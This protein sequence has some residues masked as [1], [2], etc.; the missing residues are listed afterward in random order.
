MR[1]S[2]SCGHQVELHDNHRKAI[3]SC[4][5]SNTVFWGS[6]I[7]ISLVLIGCIAERKSTPLNTQANPS[8]TCITEGMSLE[9]ALVILKSHH[10]KE[11][12]IQVVSS[13]PND[14]LRFFDLPNGRTLEI[15][16]AADSDSRQT[17]KGMF[18]STYQPKSWTSK[19]DPERSKFF[20]SF[21]QVQHYD[22]IDQ[23][24]D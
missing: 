14:H 24:K 13:D 9:D 1:Q 23:P 11:T 8:N 17:I 18:I 4:R 3:Q 19:Q 2:T 16:S 5:R 20:E 15:V 6:V 12:G 10:A 7:A 22:M 21:R